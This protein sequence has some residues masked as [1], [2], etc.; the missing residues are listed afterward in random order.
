VALG[1]GGVLPEAAPRSIGDGERGKVLL[2]LELLWGGV[3][4]AAANLGGVGSGQLEGTPEVR[5][6]GVGRRLAGSA[7]HAGGVGEGGGWGLGL[8]S[9]AGMSGPRCNMVG[10]FSSNAGR[11]G[12]VIRD[13]TAEK[14]RLR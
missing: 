7:Q 5:A 13:R 11:E 2:Y 14:R 4:P 8:V 3:V 12:P 1:G 9:E 6:A 10:K